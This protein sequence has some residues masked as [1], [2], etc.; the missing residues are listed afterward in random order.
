[1]GLG[2]LSDEVFEAVIF[3][4]DGTL[5]DSTPAVARAWTT[6]ATE[7]GLTAAEL[8]GHHGVPSASVV[9]AVVTEDRYPAALARINELE[10]AD[11]AEM[12]ANPLFSRYPPS[13]RCV[14]GQVGARMSTDGL[15]I[16]HGPTRR[17]GSRRGTAAQQRRRRSR[18]I[19]E[20]ILVLLYRRSTPS[21]RPR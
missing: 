7:F 15:I 11:V 19:A 14:D 17:R 9:R 16:G 1:M 4:M 5:I 3:D 13:G 12:V 2:R 10:I 18:D 6:W 20:A 21:A 8:A